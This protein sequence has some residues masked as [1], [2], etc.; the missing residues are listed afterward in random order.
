MTDSP[1]AWRIYYGDET[2]FSAG[3]GSV[4]DAPARNVQA[5]VRLDPRVGRF[6]LTG[7]DY[8]WWQPGDEEWFGGDRFGLFDYLCRPGRKRV[9]F[10]RSL[11]RSEYERIHQQAATDDDFPQKTAHHPDERPLE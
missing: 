5:I 4:Y 3:D 8:Y 9:L 7:H 11:T 10:G 2:T 1:P 6:I